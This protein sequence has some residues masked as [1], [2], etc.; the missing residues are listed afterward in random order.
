MRWAANPARRCTRV[1]LGWK[2][3]L[4]G[5][6][7]EVLRWLILR[8]AGVRMGELDVERADT[9]VLQVNVDVNG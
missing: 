6:V 4:N 3:S 8:E 2:T 9:V 1:I 5:V 7:G